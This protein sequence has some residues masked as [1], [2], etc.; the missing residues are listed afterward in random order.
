MFLGLP[1]REKVIL[2][3]EQGGVSREERFAELQREFE[4]LQEQDTRDEQEL[5]G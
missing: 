4:A 3:K 2:T 5:Q 1:E